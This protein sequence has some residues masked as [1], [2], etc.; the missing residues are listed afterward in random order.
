M[1]VIAG[2]LKGRKLLEIKTPSIRPTSDRV[3]EAL[4]SILG[5]RIIDCR[6]LDLFAGSGSVGIEAYSR[7]AEEVIFIDSNKES[8]KILKS[9]LTITGI[10]D[11]VEVYNTDYSNAV[12]KL[13]E[14]KRSFDM[15]FIDP[16]YKKDIAYD[17]VKKI[18][19]SNILSDYGIIIIEQS[20]KDF[21]H[22]KIEA[23][24]LVKKKT[25][26]NTLLLFYLSKV[27][28]REEFNENMRISR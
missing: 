4:F 5:N 12:N 26:G 8:I 10:S 1:R 28:D 3:K 15:I 22:E 27:V 17:V 18:F 20:E 19:K 9:N 13:A 7:G 11:S 24:E 2:L 25:Y 16:P 21:V 6:F 14:K 23:Y